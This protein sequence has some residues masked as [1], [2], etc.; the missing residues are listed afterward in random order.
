MSSSIQTT[1]AG[2]GKIHALGKSEVA[3]L[4]TGDVVVQEKVDGSQFSFGVSGGELQCRSKSV[5]INLETPAKLFT[6]AVELAKNVQSNLVSNCV[7][8]CEYLQR[9]SHNVLKY[10]RVP[11]NHLVLFDIQLA[12]G[13]YAGDAYIEMV[14]AELGI[15]ACPV[16]YS[17]PGSGLTME[18]LNEFLKRESCLGGALIEGVVI[19]ARDK[20]YTHLDGS[21]LKG[22]YVS[23]AFKETHHQVWKEV[24]PNNG[25][26]VELITNMFANPA[27]WEKAV[28]HL[29]DAGTLQESP[30]DIGELIKEVRRDVLEEGK[31]EILDKLFGWFWPKIER[32]LAYNVPEWYK[33]K[34]AEKQFENQITATIEEHKEVLDALS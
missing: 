31:Q 23:E 29:R 25:D 10:S 18:M 30:R 9:P 22:K 5:G 12:D 1:L 32:R 34:L 24:N 8:R 21:M 19:K 13:S 2:Y 14:A 27:R 11:K 26:V 7:F 15:E 17:G 20:R 33:A 4:L 6:Q 16:L 3:D 28:Q